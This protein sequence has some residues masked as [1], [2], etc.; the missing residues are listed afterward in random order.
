RGTDAGRFAFRRNIGNEFEILIRAAIAAGHLP[1]QPP[2]A[3]AAAVIGAIVE[4]LV[5]PLA[6]NARGPDV[7][8][9][10]VQALAL[11]ALRALGVGDARARGLVLQAEA[12]ARKSEAGNQEQV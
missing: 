2:A 6:S 10:S 8:Y 5:G 9:M 4:S 11:F 1:D 7:E 3:M 12:G